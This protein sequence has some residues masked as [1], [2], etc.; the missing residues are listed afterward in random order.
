VGEAEVQNL[1]IVLLQSLHFHARDGVVEPLELRTWV[2]GHLPGDAVVAVEELLPEEL[3]PGHGVPLPAHQPRRE[4][5][6]VVQVEED[7]VEDA[8]GEEGTAARVHRVILPPPFPCP[9]ASSPPD[10]PLQPVPQPEPPGATP[11]H[12]GG[13]RTSAQSPSAARRAAPRGRRRGRSLGRD[14]QTGQL[15]SSRPPGSCSHIH[16]QPEGWCSRSRSWVWHSRPAA[17]LGTA[18]S[19]GWG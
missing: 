13:H 1:V 5:V 18:P 16:P 19:Q 2:P 3:V 9:A 11:C 10:L 7:L 15:P 4:Y 6:Y 8:V 17:A 12:S 14:P